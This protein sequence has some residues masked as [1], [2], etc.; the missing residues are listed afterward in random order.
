MLTQYNAE[1]SEAGKCIKRFFALIFLPPYE[2]SVMDLRIR[3][4]ILQLLT[5]P[6]SSRCLLGNRRP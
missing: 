4:Q 2:F 3:Y 6:T 1:K 5:H